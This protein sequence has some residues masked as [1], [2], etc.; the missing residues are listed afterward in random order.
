MNPVEVWFLQHFW[1]AKLFFLV[2][3][4]KSISAPPTIMPISSLRNKG[5][6]ALSSIELESFSKL[7]DLMHGSMIF[8]A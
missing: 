4:L 6:I 7:D 8:S 5:S 2:A 3:M 1:Q